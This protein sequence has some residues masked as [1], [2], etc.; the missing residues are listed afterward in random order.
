[1]TFLDF[2]SNPAAAM[3]GLDILVHASTKAEPFGR[4]IAEGQACGCV[5]VAVRSGG[6]GEVFENEISGIGFQM[7]NADSL[8]NALQLLLNHPDKRRSIRQ[9]LI[10]EPDKKFD[11]RRLSS[12]WIQLYDFK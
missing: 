4:V 6:S 11:R 12:K 10:D 2:Q 5:V 9:N 3:R 1:M 8:A 7:G